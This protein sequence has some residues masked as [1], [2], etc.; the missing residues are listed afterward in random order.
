MLSGE[1]H[2]DERVGPNAVMETAAL[3]LLAASC[4]AYPRL[5]LRSDL[6]EWETI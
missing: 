4:I 5:E 6:D 1:V 2:G 3:L